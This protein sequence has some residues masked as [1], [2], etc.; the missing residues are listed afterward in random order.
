MTL[1]SGPRFSQPKD[2]MEP[3]SSTG[4]DNALKAVQ[5]AFY[6]IGSVVAALTYRAAKRGLLNTVAT[7]YQ[8]RVMD[9]L[10]RLLE[11]LYSEFDMASAAHWSRTKPAHGAIE[12]INEVFFRWQDDI[13]AKRRYDYG[14]PITPDVLRLTQMLDPITSDP[15]IPPNIRAAVVDLVENRLHVM[16]GIYF[17]EFERYADHLAK[18]K[19][20]PL[21]ELDDVHNR[22]VE[23]MNKQGCG[24]RDIEGEVHRIRGLIQ[25]YLRGLQPPPT[26]VA[27]P[28][29]GLAPAGS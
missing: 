26:L 8:K 7:E 24:I 4:L 28:V 19:Q 2:F 3:P 27:P 20:T 11:D 17:R 6:V 16:N 29:V 5:I 10:L 18:G 15:L 13:L 23:Q 1:L 12:H 22:V 21:T 25:D 9:R 14:T